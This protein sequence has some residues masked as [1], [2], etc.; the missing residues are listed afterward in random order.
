MTIDAIEVKSTGVSSSFDS[1]CSV[2]SIIPDVS[3]WCSIRTDDDDEIV[4]VFTV[5]KS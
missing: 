4:G 3:G 1:F 2:C 5:W